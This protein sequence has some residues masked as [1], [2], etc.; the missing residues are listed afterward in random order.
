M[1]THTNRSKWI[2]S[3]LLMA[4]MAFGAVTVTETAGTITGNGSTKSGSTFPIKAQSF[5]ITLSE[6][7]AAA[8]TLT[9]ILPVKQIT[10]DNWLRDTH[11]RMSIFKGDS[12]E[13]RFT[14]TTAANLAP[15]TLDLPGELIINGI[16]V[17]NTLKLTITQ[18]EADFIVEGSTTV[19]LSD[20]GIKPPGMGPMKVA[21]ELNLQFS[22]TVP[23]TEK[24]E[25]LLSRR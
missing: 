22:V 19:L 14:A 20:Y 2:A 11:M 13:V 24:T 9:V 6:S 10:T 7:A 4:T 16:P 15:G 17:P 8:K 1:K 25:T 12:K 18:S 23:G 5:E 3:A 21:N